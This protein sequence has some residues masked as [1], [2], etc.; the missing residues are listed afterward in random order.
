M[1]EE[2][3]TVMRVD[4]E[5]AEVQTQ[6]RSACGSCHAQEGCGTSVL[7]G[8]FGKRPVQLRVRNPVAAAPGDRVVV[9]LDEQ[10]FQITS[11]VV[12]ALPLLGLLLGAILGRMLGL[13]LA[14]ANTEPLSILG[15]LLGVAGGLALV[16]RFARSRSDD[17]RYQAVILRVLT[18][19]IGLSALAGTARPT[20]QETT[21]E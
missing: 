18:P 20:H 15:G 13:D 19:G 4:G 1:I 14:L 12:Y 6:R 2:V 10:A 21:T 16:R 3:A 7:A 11:F 8:L 17:R 5:L 9:G